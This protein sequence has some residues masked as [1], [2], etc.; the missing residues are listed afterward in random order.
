MDDSNRN[1]YGIILGR[2][3][4]TELRLNLK[5]I[6]HVI[7]G[8]DGSFKGYTVPM[9][10]LGANVFKYLNTRKIKSE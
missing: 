4:F 7:K 9:V 8:Y 5:K 6:G 1:R 2:D 10:D 3:L